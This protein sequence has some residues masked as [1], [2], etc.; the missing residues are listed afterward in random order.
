MKEKLI[1][2]TI[3]CVMILVSTI[4]VGIILRSHH[5]QDWHLLEIEDIP[6]GGRDTTMLRNTH[7]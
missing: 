7:R 3:L 5:V 4:L 6:S 1:A 2:I